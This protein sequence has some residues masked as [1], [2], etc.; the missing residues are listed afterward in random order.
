MRSL[1]IRA[2][3][4]K[5]CLV[6]NAG[7]SLAYLDAR[8]TVDWLWKTGEGVVVFRGGAANCVN[9]RARSKQ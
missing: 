6:E 2:D 7:P 4:K 1:C 8:D 9:M 5:S 3:F